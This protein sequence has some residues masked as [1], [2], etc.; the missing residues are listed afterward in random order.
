MFNNA[1]LP[2]R[3]QRTSSNFILKSDPVF[4]CFLSRGVHAE[5]I[6]WRIASTFNSSEESVDFIVKS[7]FDSP[8]RPSSLSLSPSP[9]PR[10]VVVSGRNSWVCCGR[11][12]G[13]AAA[14][15]AHVLCLCAAGCSLQLDFKLWHTRLRHRDVDARIM[16]QEV[17]AQHFGA[18]A[19]TRARSWDFLSFFFVSLL[20]LTKFVWK[21]SF[22]SPICFLI[23]PL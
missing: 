15:C 14:F 23:Y 18:R 22:C 17:Y 8:E 2:V 13:H 20:C 4:S 11:P 6:S 1:R 9:S 3:K 5:N 19:H 10:V 12:S 7:G 16:W 21:C